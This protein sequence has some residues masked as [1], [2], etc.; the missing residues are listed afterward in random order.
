MA[1]GGPD[2]PGGEGSVS[3]RSHLSISEELLDPNCLLAGTVIR[4]AGEA[5][6]ELANRHGNWLV[7]TLDIQ[8]P[9]VGGN[10]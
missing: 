5:G 9:A 4:W 8:K 3:E 2:R 10:K 1:I 7:Y 6:F